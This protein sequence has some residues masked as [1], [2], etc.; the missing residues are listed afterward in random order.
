MKRTN[1]TLIELLVVIAIIAILAGMLLPA[2]NK[3][4]ETAKQASCSSNLKQVGLG[5][6]GYAGDYADWLVPS[7]FQMTSSGPYDNTYGYY[8]SRVLQVLKYVGNSGGKTPS[9]LFNVQT[10]PKGIFV[11]PADRAPLVRNNQFSIT[12]YYSYGPSTHVAGKAM[13]FNAL[14]ATPQNQY[15]SDPVPGSGYSG[16]LT[17]G[18]VQ[19]QVKKSSGSVLMGAASAST[20]GGNVNTSNSP[21]D[22][23]NP[24][25]NTRAL[26]NNSGNFLFVDGHVT[27]RKFPLGAA[28]AHS[29]FL[30]PYVYATQ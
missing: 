11:C 29:N 23:V 27:N 6:I 30:R 16:W 28:G 19:R 22:P 12:D 3:A 20:I 10:Q 26:H 4:R 25:Y 14:T 2:L 15:P 18:Q 5:Y 9:G 1:F 17:Q 8:W 13:Y 24:Q 21:Y 7:E